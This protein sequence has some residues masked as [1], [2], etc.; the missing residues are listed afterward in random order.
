VSCTPGA[1]TTSPSSSPRRHA[2]TTSSAD[3]RGTAL[4]SSPWRSWNSVATIP[5]HLTQDERDH[6]FA[7]ADH[8]PPPRTLRSDVASLRAAHGRAA[9]DPE[10]RGLVDRLL[11]ESDEFAALWERHEVGSRAGMAKRFVHP[12]V[13]PLTLDCDILT[14]EN[15]TER[16]IVFTARPGSDDAD[17]LELLAVIGS[18]GFPSGAT[19]DTG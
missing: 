9:D 12:L 1:Q 8:T 17:R 13:G 6:L 7:L 2:V 15:L 5:G 10:V 3:I 4:R 18:Q 14:A 19:V 16:L 11:R